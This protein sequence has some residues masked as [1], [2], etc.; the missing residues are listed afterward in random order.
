MNSPPAILLSTVRIEVQ[1]RTE[2]RSRRQGRGTR[3]IRKVRRAVASGGRL[4]TK[5]NNQLVG[6]RIPIFRYPIRK[7]FQNSMGMI[8][9]VLGFTPVLVS[10]MVDFKPWRRASHLHTWISVYCMKKIVL[11][12]SLGCLHPRLQELSILDSIKTDR[13]LINRPYLA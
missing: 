4:Q 8:H 5:G 6:L 13:I 3:R 2:I 9:L 11:I 1:V 10:T 7:L 12:R